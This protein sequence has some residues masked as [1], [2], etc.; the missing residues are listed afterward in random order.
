MLSLNTARGARDGR[1]QNTR[2][3]QVYIEVW[4][5]DVVGGL[6]GGGD[7]GFL[8]AQTREARTPLGVRQ[9]LFNI[10]TIVTSKSRPRLVCGNR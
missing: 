9:Y 10:V 8:R 3:L 2:R 4:L 1:T 6:M 5:Y 7:L